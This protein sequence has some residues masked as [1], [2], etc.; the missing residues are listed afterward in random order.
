MP[1]SWVYH[2]V[3]PPYE[4]LI[5]HN[6]LNRLNDPYYYYPVAFAK[7]E[8]AGMKYRFLC[9]AQAKFGSMQDTHFT[10]IEI[11]KPITGMPY[12]TCLHKLEF[13]HIWQ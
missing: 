5:F 13:S 12:A 3:I 10:G 1:S 6:V 7:R 2:P 8:E 9:I 4:A 11:Y